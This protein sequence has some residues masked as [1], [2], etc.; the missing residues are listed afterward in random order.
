MT[1]KTEADLCAHFIRLLP[2]G[3]TAY[4][5]TAGWDILLS[6]NEDGFQIGVEA[7][8]TLNAKVISQALERYAQYGRDYGPDCRAVLVPAGKSH[9]FDLIA[10]YL[11]IVIIRLKPDDRYYPARPP[12]PLAPSKRGS[13]FSH[14][15]WHE[16]WPT[17]RYALPAYIPDVAAGKPS[18]VSLT[19]WKIKALKVC[20]IID[21]NGFVTKADFVGLRLD[22]RRWMTPGAEWLKV[23]EVVDGIGRYVPGQYFR[24]FRAHHPTV[25]EQI[26]AT[27]DDW[28]KES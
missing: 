5:E 1:Y 16:W 22:Y 19:E 13:E 18:P 15:D 12:L 28:I 10:T 23:S 14:R 7:K 20:A 25:Y 3:W 26:K 6:R 17:E 2:E 4:P 11:G 27:F 24:D 8:L 9:D 21:R